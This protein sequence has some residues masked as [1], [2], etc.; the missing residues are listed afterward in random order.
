ME[1]KLF[2]GYGKA[3]ITPKIGTPIGGY[4]NDAHRLAEEIRDVPFVTCVAFTDAR[5]NTVLICS[6][7]M[8]HWDEKMIA[9]ARPAVEAATGV[10]GDHLMVSA[11]HTHNCISTSSPHLPGEMEYLRWIC[12]ERL[13]VA[14][15]RAMASRKEAKLYAGKQEF[16]LTNFARHFKLADGRII[17]RGFVPQSEYV[18][19]GYP[20]DCML[21]LVKIVREGEKDILLMN[22]QTHPDM[23]GGGVTKFVSADYIGAVRSYLEISLDC[24]FA[25]FQGGCGD[26][27]PN[28]PQFK[29]KWPVLNSDR[30]AKRLG[31]QAISMLDKLTEVA[32]GPVDC[33]MR[34]LVCPVDRSDDPLLEK[35]KAVWNKYA[36]E[37]DTAG[38]EALAK[39]MGFHNRYHARGIVIRSEE[40]ESYTLEVDAVRVGGIGF[41]TAPYEMFCA[42]GMWV[43][44]NSPYDITFVLTSANGD[45]AYIA[46]DLAYTYPCYEVNMRLFARGTAEMLADNMVQM[47]K[48]ME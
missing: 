27:V 48:E 29:E 23:M 32:L 24:Q 21:Q 1:E 10:P 33:R 8:I 9:M 5:D 4:G 16:P 3:D 37:G 28:S 36:L 31:D 20:A 46:S 38:S 6:A 2:V 45:N 26:L 11:V 14:A 13:V 44:E 40:A 47:L 39:E 15:Q 18:D 42:N 34:K 25:Y 22:W 19:H 17:G 35:A 43:K 41:A 7:D 12:T 30:Y